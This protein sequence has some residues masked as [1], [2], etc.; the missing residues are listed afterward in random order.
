[1][2]PKLIDQDNDR[3]EKPKT[4]R[5]MYKEENKEKPKGIRKRNHQKV[6]Y[7]KLKR[8]FFLQ[9][10]LTKSANKGNNYP[11]VRKFLL[12]RQDN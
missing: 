10:A 7:N 4:R 1:M 9:K 12:E 3:E 8:I 11:K 6:I 5:G 2:L